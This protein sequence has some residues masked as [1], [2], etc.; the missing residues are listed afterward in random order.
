MAKFDF[1]QSRYAKFFSSK[2]N[3]DFLQTFINTEGV[4]GVNYD[5]WRSQCNIAQPTPVESDGSATF[6]Q[7]CRSLKAAP[8]MD[9]RAP[10]G[11]GLQEDSEGI[12]FYTASIPDFISTAY[13][14]NA[15]ERRYKEETFAQ[16]GNDV[17]I[18]VAWTQN[19]QSKIDQAAVTLNYLT[20]KLMTT[21]IEDYTGIGRGIQL[22]LHKAAIPEE[23]FSTCGEKVWTADDATILTYM[24]EIEKKYRD[25]WGYDGQLVWKMTKNFFNS[26]FLKNAEVKEYVINYRKLNYLAYT[27]SM[28]VTR[29]MFLE[30]FQDFDGLSPIE[31]VEERERNLTSTADTFING[32]DDK[33]VVLC[34]AGKVCDIRHKTPIDQAIYTA[35]GSN[36]VDKVFASAMDGLCTVINTTINNGELKEWATEVVMSACPALNEFMRHVIVDVTSA[37]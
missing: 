20:A 6:T 14:E 2:T 5:W 31:I 1:N 16:F 8:L 27:D 28:S 13:H 30:A 33:Y 26:V 4:I 29:N 11:K 9:L 37:D 35:Y 10:L 23:N 17:D 3:R 25:K 15:M 12:S 19:L 7:K 32:W 34:P 24:V 18:V 36:A 22:P 21:G